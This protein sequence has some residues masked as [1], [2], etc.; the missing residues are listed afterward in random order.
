MSWL[1]VVRAAV[2]CG[3]FL[4]ATPALA[5][6]GGAQGPGGSDCH[7]CDAR[8]LLREK[9]RAERAAGDLVQKDLDAATTELTALR[10]QAASLEAER[11][12]LSD[13]LLGQS[14]VSPPPKGDGLSLLDQY[15][16]MP[17][18]NSCARRFLGLICMNAM[19]RMTLFA[20]S[21]N[22]DLATA[23]KRTAELKRRL[24][25]TRTD[26]TTMTAEVARLKATVAYLRAQVGNG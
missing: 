21:L 1:P 9:I 25:Q 11:Q 7:G 17:I 5:Q 23:Q 26:I 16:A 8:D 12:Q 15:P 4:V 10:T 6:G 24:A 22:D 20:S 3:F 19:G 13:K 2:T 14:S 18:V